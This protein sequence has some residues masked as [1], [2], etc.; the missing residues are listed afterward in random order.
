[1]KNINNCGEIFSNDRTYKNTNYNILQQVGYSL[2]EVLSIL[3]FALSLCLYLATTGSISLLVWSYLHHYLFTEIAVLQ[4]P[5]L[6]LISN[7]TELLVS[8]FGFLYRYF[9]LREL[10]LYKTCF[11]IVYVFG[12][13]AV[14][15]GYSLKHPYT[16]PKFAILIRVVLL[17]TKSYMSCY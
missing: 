14:D 6:F 16:L 4:N 13:N 7:F 11:Y 2:N 5:A 12:L 1:M 3:K 9:K 15:R 8:G 10:L 17:Y